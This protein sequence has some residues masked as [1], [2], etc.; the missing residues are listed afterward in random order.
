MTTR[1]FFAISLLV[2]A[3]SASAQSAAK[4]FTKSFNATDKTAVTLDLPGTIELK[5]WDNATVRIE[6]TVS[7]ASGNTAML[8]ELAN[9]GRYNLTSKPV[10]TKLLIQSPNLQKQVRVK[11]EVLKETVTYTV[12]VPKDVIVEQPNLISA[13]VDK[14]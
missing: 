13:A 1:L 7:L 9:V 6:I 11:G 10:G 8:N 3:L 2:P 12:F 14:K 5:V 4:T